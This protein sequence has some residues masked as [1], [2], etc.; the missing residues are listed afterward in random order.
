MNLIIDNRENDLIQLIEKSDINF[1]KKNLILGDISFNKDENELLII[2]RKT[3]PDLLASIKDG[4]YRE[5]KLRLIN[6][7]K[8]HIQ[9]YYLIE[10][11]IYRH[12]Q[13]ELIMSCI[14]NTMI[15]DNLKVI[16]SYNLNDTLDIVK[17]LIKKTSEFQK[18]LLRKDT[19][20][21][22]INNEND[23]STVI[24]SE[25]K[26]NMTKEICSIA[27]FKQIPGVSTKCAKSILEKYSNISSLIL[28]Y[29]TL[30]NEDAKKYLLKD[31][32]IE[33]KRIGIKLSEKIYNYLI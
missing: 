4:R 14:F 6:K 29:Q 30:D 16:Y 2:E 17:K 21:E 13:K 26:L 1:E 25:K 22:K 8:E 12:K 28:K 5:Q 23:Y 9:I 7:Q 18:L 19:D 32:I 10:G 31:I 33:K 20:N 24:K 3:L 27:M 15:R 11:D